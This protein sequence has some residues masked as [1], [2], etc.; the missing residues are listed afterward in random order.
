V[1][2][3]D[4]V[5]PNTTNWLL[6]QLMAVPTTLYSSDATTSLTKPIAYSVPHGMLATISEVQT[7]AAGFLVTGTPTLAT[8]TIT[9][10]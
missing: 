2:A 1:A 3:F 9:L 5:V 10:P 8:K 4:Q 6:Y 7:D